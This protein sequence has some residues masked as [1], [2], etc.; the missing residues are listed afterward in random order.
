[1]LPA[2][3]SASR[4]AAATFNGVF[5]RVSSATPLA[6]VKS[7]NSYSAHI[8]TS[9]YTQQRSWLRSGIH[10]KHVPNSRTHSHGQDHHAVSQFNVRVQTRAYSSKKGKAAKVKT[11]SVSTSKTL[12]APPPNSKNK[13]LGMK[14][15]SVAAQTRD[16]KK[17]RLEETSREQTNDMLDSNNSVLHQQGGGHSHGQTNHQGQGRG[18]DHGN[19]KAG[20]AHSYASLYRYGESEAQAASEEADEGVTVGHAHRGHKRPHTH[21]YK[22][23]TTRGKQVKLTEVLSILKSEYKLMSLAMVGLGASTAA[24][25]AFPDALGT[26]VDVLAEPTT[27]D[28]Y[29]R[30]KEITLNMVGIITVGAGATFL[31]ATLLEMVGQKIGASLRKKLYGGIMA[32]D[33]AFFDVNRSG[34]LVNR[35]GIDVHETAEHLVENVGSFTESAMKSASAVG[36]MVYIS[37]LLT[38]Y[39]AGVVPMIIGGALFFGK[40][41]KRLSRKHLDALATSTQM[42]AERFGAI[43]TVVLCDQQQVE[44]REYGKVIDMSYLYAERLAYY[45]G[46]FLGCSFFI[47]NG[48]LLTVVGLGGNMVINNTLSVGQLTAFCLYAGMLSGSVSEVT[49]SASGILRAQGS[50]SR[51]FQL[52]E[53]KPKLGYGTKKLAEGYNGNIRF[54][55]VGFA[56]PTAPDAQI[57]EKLDLSVTAGEMVAL[58]GRS[59]CGKSSVIALLQGL[60]EPN[61]GSITIDGVDLRDLD[62]AWLRSQMG[63]VQ[64]EPVVFSGTIRS[65]IVYTKPDATQEEV[66]EAAKLSNAHEFITHL[67]KGYDTHVG[68][69]GASLSGGQRQRIAIARA[70]LTKPRFL[71]LDE[72]TSALDEMSEGV[73]LNSLKSL[74]RSKKIT[75]LVVAHH[76][77]TLAVCDRVVV[78]DTGGVVTRDGALNIM[79]DDAGGQNIYGFKQDC[80]R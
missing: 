13:S 53:A 56:Y 30:I 61:R 62:V 1:M 31:H 40:Y 77:N 18:G 59:G 2:L 57:I 76:L 78:M 6:A 49:E 19:C 70:L 12:A 75:T 36:A 28:T 43:R 46:L 45:Q 3:N 64:Q 71:V 8:Q 60:Y 66:V 58:T 74:N 37:P 42:A 67:P 68:E 32:Q 20:D 54:N 27:V 73:V 69:R 5:S 16:L 14:L 11:R 41:I 7:S 22:L 48:V 63:Y 72:S 38:F 15:A 35:L 44:A 79:S 23:D 80:P 39:S 50:A 25:I 65:N 34:E 51:L 4:N 29:A 9:V 17:Q 21:S 33:A 26:I 47:G 10:P 55:G 24:T 52:L